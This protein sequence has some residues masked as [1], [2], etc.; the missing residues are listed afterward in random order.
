MTGEKTQTAAEASA[1]THKRTALIVAASAE[2]RAI[3]ERGLGE[4]YLAEHADPATAEDMLALLTRIRP[5]VVL[6][7]LPHT[8]EHDVRL[9]EAIVKAH[10][11][12][13]VVFVQQA[14]ED[15]VRAVIRAGASAFIVDG[16]AESRVRSVVEVAVERFT[17]INALQTELQKAQSDL[18]A[19]KIIERAKGLIM[20]RKNMTER[21]AYDSM[22][23]MAMAQ[24]KPLREI[25]E[26]ILSFSELLL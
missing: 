13:I 16:L 24:G 4:N 5:D 1:T 6:F 19:R 15:N 7:A 14:D 2:A 8:K 18:A 22:R 23:R 10:S 17:L 3:L 12:P 25:A 9:F 20:E 21:E 11:A 26:S